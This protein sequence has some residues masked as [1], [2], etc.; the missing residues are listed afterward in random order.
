M[1]PDSS[2]DEAGIEALRLGLDLEM[3]F[4]DTAEMYGAGHSEEVVSQALEGRRDRVVVAS[5]VSPR[6]HKD[7]V[8]APL[9]SEEH[10]SEL[11][12]P[13]HLVCRLVLAK[14]KGDDCGKED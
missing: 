2:R 3:K 6:S 12:S 8:T 1:G 9:R 7:P 4:I 11:Q 10:T 5:K 13:V 14:T